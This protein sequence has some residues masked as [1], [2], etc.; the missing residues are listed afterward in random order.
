M[1]ITKF[2]EI[3]RCGLAAL[4]FAASASAAFAFP[5][6]PIRFIVCTVPGGA[7]DVTTRIVAQK[8]SEKIGQQII[9]ENKPGGDTLLGI[10]HVKEQPADGYTILAQSLN[11]NT[12]PYIKNNPGYAPSDFIGIGNMSTIPFLM[13]VGGTQPDKTLGEYVA[14]AQKEKLTYGHGGVA[15]APQIAADLFL[16]AYG[17]KEIEVPYKGNGAVMPDIMAGRTS[18]FFDAYVSSGEFIRSGKM[19]ALAVAAPNRIAPLPDVPTFK[20]LGKD[21]SFGVWLGLLARKETP[22]DVVKALS[23]ALKAAL[24]DLGPRFRSEGAD[25][26]FVTS[27]EFTAQL[28]KEYSDMGK[29]ASDLKWEKQ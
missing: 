27:Q 12:L 5:T 8:M 28:A 20:E 4:A 14:R 6:K 3:L 1:N 17:L 9:V 13:V 26:T 7:T 15:G 29:L 21:F 24:E 10:L 2:G 11:F 16:K 23:D 25:P 19:R 18:M 22:P